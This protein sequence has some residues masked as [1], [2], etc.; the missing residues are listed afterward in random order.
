[1]GAAVGGVFKYGRL[2]V[3]SLTKTG[4]QLALG[5]T[6]MRLLNNVTN[7]QLR[8]AVEYL[9]REGAKYGSGSTGAMIRAYEWDSNFPV[10]LVI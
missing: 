9:Y 7:P 8:K 5:T 3:R 2:S 6:C 1:M 4:G 10:R